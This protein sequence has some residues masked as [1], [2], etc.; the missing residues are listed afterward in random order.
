LTFNQGATSNSR[1]ATGPPRRG[2]VTLTQKIDKINDEP[3]F[4]DNPGTC[5]NTDHESTC[6]TQYTR[7]T[8]IMKKK[9][10]MRG[11][12]GGVR[13]DI[14][15]KHVQY[16]SKRELPRVPRLS[17]GSFHVGGISLCWSGP[18]SEYNRTRPIPC[19]NTCPILSLSLPISKQRWLNACQ[20]R[21]I[22]I[23]LH[24]YCTVLYIIGS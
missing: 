8:R 6:T 5:S 1:A 17:D 12:D 10:S 9:S 7:N 22:T 19:I 23:S 2:M 24:L 20:H 11:R 21:W 4:F 13:I 16:H 3:R 14:P 18:E 15:N